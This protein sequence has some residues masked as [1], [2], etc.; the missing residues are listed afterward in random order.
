[1]KHLPLLENA[2]ATPP[3]RRGLLRRA[4]ASL[5]FRSA[6]SLDKDAARNRAER[7]FDINFRNPCSR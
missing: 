7:L 6:S 5:R 2:L 3:A 4:I 1:M